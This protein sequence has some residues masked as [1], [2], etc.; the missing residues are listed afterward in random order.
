MKNNKKI[1]T[2]Q[3]A[4]SVWSNERKVP[5]SFIISSPQN[6]SETIIY[7]KLSNL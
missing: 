3:V 1:K 6:E 4:A 2:A 7:L 5:R